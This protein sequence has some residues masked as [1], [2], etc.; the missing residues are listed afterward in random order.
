MIP[1]F[2][3][4]R[5]LLNPADPPW[6][7]HEK[8]LSIVEV[9]MR[10]V[11]QDTNLSG[12]GY[13]QFERA[14]MLEEQVRARTGDLEAALDLLNE[15]NGRLASA[16]RETEAAR[17]NLADAIEA[18][19]EG[20]ALFGADDIL[21]MCNSRF[22][23]QMPDIRARLHPGQSFAAY[24]DMV[25]ASPDL[26]LPEGTSPQDWAIDRLRR[27]RES[28]VLFT[29]ALTRDRW[30]QVSEHRTGDHGTVIV[31]TDVTAILR[32]ERAARVRLLDDQARVVRATLDHISQGVC[33]FDAD[34]HL[35]GWNERAAFRRPRQF[36]T[37][38]CPR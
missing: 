5:G 25:S 9:L 37:R 15:S 26:L 36:A 12:A 6:R 7:A 34:A 11:E 27:H 19:Q 35:I 32:A 4:A 38:Q 23:L 8:L 31:Q 21:V 29:I 13:A 17:R 3:T 24:I 16:N 30:L 2:A 28:S 10:R 33:I 18:V 1:P 20:F 22:G 14:A